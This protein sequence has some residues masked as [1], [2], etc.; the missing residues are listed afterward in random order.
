MKKR[1]ITFLICLSMLF[2]CACNPASVQKGDASEDNKIQAVISMNPS[3]IEV[4]GTVTSARKA[5]SDSMSADVTAK[6][7]TLYDNSNWQWAY[8]SAESCFTQRT[9][10]GLE[11]FKNGAG[12]SGKNAPYA[13]TVTDDRSSSVSVYDT[14]KIKVKGYG[15]NTVAP[16]GVMLA[17][18]GE[19]KEAFIYT[20]AQDG[21]LSL[22][23][24][25]NGNISLVKQVGN[26]DTDMFTNDSALGVVVGIY[27][28]NRLVFQEILGNAA[29]LGDA[30][31]SVAFPTVS[32][33]QMKK[34]D[35]FVITAQ[36]ITDKNGIETGSF[37]LPDGT[38][39]V[40][41]PITVSREVEITDDKVDLTE[42][43]ESE[44]IYFLDSTKTSR[45][46]VVYPE[47]A[48]DNLLEIS[49]D[50]RS[51]M[52]KKLETTVLAK[53]DG[54]EIKTE[55][56]IHLGETSLAGSKAAVKEIKENRENNA[57]DFIIRMDGTTLIIAATTEIGLQSALEY[58]DANYLTDSY[59]FVPKNINYISSSKALKSLTINGNSISKYQIVRARTASYIEVAAIDELAVTLTKLTGYDIPVVDDYAK[60]SN[61]EIVVGTTLRT[62]ADYN[63]KPTKNAGSDYKF[64]VK[65]N[66]LYVT[67]DQAYGI[68]AGIMKFIAEIQKT[69]GNLA[70]GYTYKGT[71]DGGY[72][73]TDGYKLT[74]ADEFN[75]TAL[76]DTW[77]KVM[78]TGTNPVG[79]GYRTF[80]PQNS[81]VENGALVQSLE[82]NKDEG[83]IFG[84]SVDTTGKKPLWFQFGYIEYRVKMP[85]QTGAEHALWCSARNDYYRAE[86]WMELDIT[87]LGG[88]PMRHHQT[89]HQF[90]TK[91]ENMWP[92]S[93]LYYKNPVTGEDVPVGYEYHT[94][95]CEWD[96][97]SITFYNDGMAY[98]T[99]DVSNSTFE[100][101]DNP[102]F[103]RLD[104]CVVA[105]VTPDRL[106]DPENFV[107]E[108]C[109]VD[110]IRIYQKADNG[111]K[112]SFTHL[113]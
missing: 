55:Y 15:K 25:E 39:V 58:F 5:V 24:T 11:S 44:R 78:D 92:I 107:N 43:P 50:F 86:Y 108:K 26:I 34:G 100:W 98:A 57:N 89:V 111:A 82:Y 61:Y 102:V 65:G 85:V 84:G 47:G 53:E 83:I 113:G 33:V 7:L 3:V 68:N 74:W 22:G 12:E 23:D 56:T 97:D 54:K 79:E 4:D 18:T 19:E 49:E 66:K 110:Y 76:S 45:F 37:D 40:T 46:T 109:Y 35:S 32:N 71:Y 62:S 21:T 99:L 20:A 90:T 30:V 104:T 88:N 87:E 60:S 70:D 48:S 105:G 106:M 13:Y 36:M 72:T 52:A 95:G 29:L 64:E 63:F 77:R 51:Q 96:T 93:E 73:L 38:S 8:E 59:S 69:G 9:L 103:I 41:V 75:G 42:I 91:R 112:L 27:V 28:N 94:I 31:T 67:S 81:Y 16:K 17:F 2:C 10:R 6:T 101:T 80:S 14:S 1:I